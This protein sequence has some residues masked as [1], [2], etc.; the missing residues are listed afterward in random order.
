MELER[1]KTYVSWL[2]SFLQA[3]DGIRYG[4]V[5]GVQTCALPILSEDLDALVE[6][7]TALNRTDLGG[8]LA[9]PYSYLAMTRRSIYEFPA[10]ATPDQ[11]HEQRL[12]IQPSEIGRASCRERESWP[13]AA[14]SVSRKR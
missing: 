10:P 1:H 11:A 14:A 6:L 9:I 7:Q 13:V 3:E 4:R 2:I 12:V 8:Y 5:A